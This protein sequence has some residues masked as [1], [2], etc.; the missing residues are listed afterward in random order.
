M[1][2]L[3]EHLEYLIFFKY[4]WCWSSTAEKSNYYRSLFQRFFFF[5]IHFHLLYKFNLRENRKNYRNQKTCDQSSTNIKPI[6]QLLNMWMEAILCIYIT[7]V[8]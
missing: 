1:P 7:E 3:I 5:E 6:K 4:Y 8:L 2:I